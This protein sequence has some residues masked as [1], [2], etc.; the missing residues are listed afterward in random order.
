MICK[1]CYISKWCSCPTRSRRMSNHTDSSFSTIWLVSSIR[2]CAAV[3]FSHIWIIEG[4]AAF[5]VDS[6]QTVYYCH[7]K[8]NTFLVIGKL[9]NLPLMIWHLLP[10]R[11]HLYFSFDHFFTTVTTRNGFLKPTGSYS[12]HVYSR[13]VLQAV[14]IH[15]NV[16]DT[17]SLSNKRFRRFSKM[18]RMTRQPILA[19][20]H[21]KFWRRHR[22]YC[23]IN[24][25]EGR[26]Q[27]CEFA[28]VPPGR[29][30]IKRLYCCGVE[31]VIQREGP[32]AGAWGLLLKPSTS[33]HLSFRPCEDKKGVGRERKKRESG[34]G[35]GADGPEEEQSPFGKAP[36]HFPSRPLHLTSSHLSPI[37]NLFSVRHAWP[38]PARVPAAHFL[39]AL[40]S[41]PLVLTPSASPISMILS[42]YAFPIFLQLLL[43]FFSSPRLGFKKR[44]RMTHDYYCIRIKLGAEMKWLLLLIL[45]PWMFYYKADTLC[46]CHSLRLY[47]DI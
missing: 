10:A 1:I 19:H 20:N 13:G 24:T 5:A 31:A 43:F 41:L 36:C 27:G 29:R 8:K 35:K 18:P 2:I 22:P 42:R 14:V 21:F 46:S 26:Q 25:R 45:S 11:Y 6:E 39:P 34:E 17:P 16:H 15:P 7:Y 9:A 40:F 12:L 37:Y 4:C 3:M 33:I 44:W 38:D 28:E 30:Q 23:L 32:V 47:T